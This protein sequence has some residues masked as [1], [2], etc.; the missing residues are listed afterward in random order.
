[1][2]VFQVGGSVRDELLGVEPKDRDWVVINSSPEEMEEKGFKP[3]GKDF[4]VF[5]HPET[6]EEYALARTERKSGVGYKGFKF[7][8]DSSVTLE[9]DLKRR[10]F[11]INA[12]AKDHKGRIIDPFGGR[13]HLKNKTFK[14]TSPAF[15]EDPLRVLRFARFKSYKQLNDFDLHEETKVLFGKIVASTELKDL[16]PERVWMETKKALE[17]NF[18]DKFFKTLIKYHL[19]DPWF[20]NLK[21]VSCDGD[22]PELKW[23]D[24]QRINCFQLSASLPIPNSYI[25][26]IDSLKQVINFIES[27]NKSEKLRLLEKMNVRRNYEILM[28]CKQ[29]ESL[30]ERQ[31]YLEKIFKSVMAIDFSVLANLSESEVSNQKQLL[32]YEALHEII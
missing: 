30:N 21:S 32:Y 4:P 9:E 15:E 29:Y 5:L 1:M 24:M 7:Y 28:H 11:T 19:T 3:I 8:F 13:E 22:L 2:K 16:S 25:K 17:N 18:S 12:I 23:A 6:N 26:V 14:H 10:D 27:S 31:D 20:K